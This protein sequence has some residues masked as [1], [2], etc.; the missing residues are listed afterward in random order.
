MMLTLSTEQKPCLQGVPEKNALLSQIFQTFS[1]SLS[2]F[3][4]DFLR[5]ACAE[6]CASHAQM[7]NVKLGILELPLA[8]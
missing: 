6:S 7:T 8:Q 4:L 3:K 5:D 1:L 2:L